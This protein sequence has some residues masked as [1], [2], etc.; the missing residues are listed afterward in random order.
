M[1]HE[2]LRDK[3]DQSNIQQ[4]DMAKELG[5]QRANIISMFKAGKTRVPLKSIP[6]IAKIL[7]VDPKQ[8]L[9]MSMLEYCPETLKAVEQVFGGAITKNEQGILDEIR[10]LSQGTDP[11]ITSIAHRQAVVELVKSLMIKTA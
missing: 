10:K 8:M 1:F 6:H 11:E 4:S 2:F 5:F 7:N 3:I 9:R